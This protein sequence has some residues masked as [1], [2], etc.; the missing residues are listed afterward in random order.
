VILVVIVSAVVIDPATPLHRGD[1]TNPK[2][3]VWTEVAGGVAILDEKST[4]PV[5]FEYPPCSPSWRYAG[6][7]D[8]LPD[9]DRRLPSREAQGALHDAVALTV[10]VTVA[11]VWALTNPNQSTLSYVVPHPSKTPL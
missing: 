7:R 4:I 8:L 11:T 2:P 6:C 10:I 9:V 3:N 5:T 1:R